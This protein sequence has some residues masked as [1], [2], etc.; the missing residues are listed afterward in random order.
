MRRRTT[1]LN[2]AAAVAA[3]ATV[4]T[5]LG[6]APATSFA[7]ETGSFHLESHAV[8]VNNSTDTATF[9]LNF[10]REPNFFVAEGEAS[11]SFQIEVDADATSFEQPLVF[12][13]IDAVVRGAEISQAEGLP[14]R[15]R[16][17]GDDGGEGSG[18]WGAIRG[19]VPFD[20]DGATLTFTTPLDLIADDDGKFRYRINVIEDGS[21]T[22]E[23]SAAIIPV[24]AALWGGVLMLGGAGVLHKLRGRSFR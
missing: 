23:V 15:D 3:A 24:P 12:E 14:V 9:Q 20:L 16:E 10:N 7:H 4:L 18:G 22:S 1:P 5:G 6:F 11:E 21:I 19:F 13:D 2:L 17:G 8:D